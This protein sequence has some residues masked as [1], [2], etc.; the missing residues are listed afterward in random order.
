ME[1]WKEKPAKRTDRKTGRSVMT[2]RPYPDFD[3]KDG[4]VL[5][6]LTTQE[7]EKPLPKGGAVVG[8]DPYEWVPESDVDLVE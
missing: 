2:E 8:G 6:S 5:R 4:F 1:N 3:W 7:R